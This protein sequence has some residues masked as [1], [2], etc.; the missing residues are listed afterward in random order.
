[1]AANFEFVRKVDVID[2]FHLEEIISGYYTLSGGEAFSWVFNKIMKEP[3]GRK[4]QIFNTGWQSEPE[5]IE[6]VCLAMDD[7]NWNQSILLKLREIN[8]GSKSDVKNAR[9][10]RFRKHDMCLK[11]A[12]ILKT[13]AI[14]LFNIPPSLLSL[15]ETKQSET[16]STYST[17]WLAIQQATIAQFF[18]PRRNP[19]AKKEEVI[20]WINTQAVSAGLGESNNIASTIFTIIKPDNHDPKKKRV[21]PQLGQ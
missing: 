11:D 3:Q 19:D 14:E 9:E 2:F 20:E 21:E 7:D 16:A 1:M 12:A 6:D 17:A 18:N 5:I 13:D 15:P 4:V 10:T 8:W